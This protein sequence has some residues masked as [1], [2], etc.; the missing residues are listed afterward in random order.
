MVGYF[1]DDEFS[2]LYLHTPSSGSYA[3]R[4]A[5]GAG[6]WTVPGS[7]TGTPDR[8]VFPG[9]FNADRFTDLALYTY[10][11]GT[12]ACLLYTSPSPRD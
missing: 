8:L 1:G 11:T 5:D 2:D 12:W 6:D 10:D 4:F 3:V 7:G 9:H